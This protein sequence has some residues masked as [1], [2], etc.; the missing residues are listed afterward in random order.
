MAEVAPMDNELYA[1]IMKAWHGEE[2]VSSMKLP[3]AG[4]ISMGDI[5]GEVEGSGQV[6][7]NDAEFR[8]LIEPRNSGQQQAMSEYYGKSNA[9]PEIFLWK[10]GA[11]GANCSGVKRAQSGVSHEQVSGYVTYGG[12]SRITLD[13]SQSATYPDSGIHLYGGTVYSYASWNGSSSEWPGGTHG[14]YN[15]MWDYNAGGGAYCRFPC[16]TPLDNYWNGVYIDPLIYGYEFKWH[17]DGFMHVMGYEFSWTLNCNG[18][19]TGTSKHDQSD[20]WMTHIMNIKDARGGYNELIGGNSQ[21]HRSDAGSMHLIH[22]KAVPLKVNNCVS[23]R[24][25]SRLEEILTTDEYRRYQIWAGQDPD[26]PEP[27]PPIT[28]EQWLA[29]NPGKTLPDPDAPLEIPEWRPES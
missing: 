20:G 24:G 29:E 23:T 17:T 13:H 28:P 26:A 22:I 8:K 12:S 6:S 7:L 10:A 21:L 4:Q 2:E 11:A 3:D 25:Q 1:K 14:R 9:P 27:P 15:G 19:S 16:S 18:N 5:R